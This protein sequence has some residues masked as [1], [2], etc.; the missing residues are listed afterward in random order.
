[1]LGGAR[2]EETHGG[3]EL[4]PHGDFARAA[5]MGARHL[6]GLKGERAPDCAA[7]IQRALL[8]VEKTL[9]IHLRKVPEIKM[10]GRVLGRKYHECSCCSCSSLNVCLEAQ[11]ECVCGGVCVCVQAVCIQNMNHMLL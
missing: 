7:E 3:G 6:H 10:G 2:A 4:Q 1:M 8:N 5:F 9:H 11:L